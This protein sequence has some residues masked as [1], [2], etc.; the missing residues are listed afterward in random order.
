MAPPCWAVS[1]PFLAASLALRAAAEAR[2][3]QLL[4]PRL[5]QPHQQEWAQA[6]SQRSPRATLALEEVSALQARERA[7]QPGSW[8]AAHLAGLRLCHSLDS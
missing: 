8:A 5:P 7:S 2:Q 6:S 3:R 1:Q 4:G